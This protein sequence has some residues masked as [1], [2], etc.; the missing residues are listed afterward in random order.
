MDRT[1]L[2]LPAAGSLKSSAWL[3]GPA[4]LS[5]SLLSQLPS[6]WPSLSHP[7]PPSRFLLIP[8]FAHDSTKIFR[9]TPHELGAAGH[10]DASG[11]DRCGLCPQVMSDEHCS[12]KEKGV[13]HRGLN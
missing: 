2:L 7:E 6:Q 8:A 10:W 12:R 5:P 1:W 9:S 3:S 11:A 4:R 13:Q